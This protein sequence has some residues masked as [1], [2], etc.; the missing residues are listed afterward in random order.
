[1][2]KLFL[3]KPLHWALLVAVVA[4]FWVLGGARLHVTGFNLFV[5]L[6]AITAVALVA[7]VWVTSS[8]TEQVT[9]DPIPA[10]ED[11]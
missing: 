2:D 5:G 1:M 3:G 9:R 8:A 6:V 7:L 10:P 4:G 11:E